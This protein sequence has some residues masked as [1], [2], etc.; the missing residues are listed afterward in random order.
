[1]G[2]VSQLIVCEDRCVLSTAWMPVVE[3]K[4]LCENELWDLKFISQ[5]PCT[6]LPSTPPHGHIDMSSS[7]SVEQRLRVIPWED[8][9]FW[10]NAWPWLLAQLSC[11]WLSGFWNLRSSSGSGGARLN[12]RMTHLAFGRIHTNS[13]RS[14][15]KVIAGF[16]Q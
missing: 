13:P 16:Q 5:A 4:D 9:G 15:F 11:F 8:V 6:L 7:C 2:H 10:S 3:M 12:E 14:I 1:M